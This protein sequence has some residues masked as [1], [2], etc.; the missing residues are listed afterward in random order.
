M[1]VKLT[2]CTNVHIVYQVNTNFFKVDLICR[3]S[4]CTIVHVVYEEDKIIHLKTVYGCG[5]LCMGS[6]NKNH[7]PALR[8]PMASPLSFSIEPL[9]VDLMLT[10]ILFR[11][12]SLSRT[13][14][15]GQPIWCGSFNCL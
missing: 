1:L 6:L 15:V 8:L 3:T 13:A 14:Q 7:K 9:N 10:L 11:K 4:M 5:N 12:K 2:M